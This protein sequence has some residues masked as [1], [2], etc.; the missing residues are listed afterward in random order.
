MAEPF[1]N[2]VGAVGVAAASNTCVDC[3]E[4]ILAYHPVNYDGDIKR[5]IADRN[6]WSGN[7]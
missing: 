3:F 6:S 2:V 4:A 5:R 7:E 1:G